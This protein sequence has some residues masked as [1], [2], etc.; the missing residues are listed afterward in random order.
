MK[1][2]TIVTFTGYVFLLAAGC[3]A[4]DNDD[5]GGETAIDSLSTSLSSSGAGPSTTSNDASGD[6][7]TGSADSSESG[8]PPAPTCNPPDSHEPNDAEDDAAELPEFS[9]QC[10]VDSS[11]NG[12]LAGDADIDWL[13]YRGGTNDFICVNDPTVDVVASG[14]IRFCQYVDCISGDPTTQ[15]C[16]SGTTADTSDD[17]GRPGCCTQGEDIAFSMYVGCSSDAQVF[18]RIDQGDADVC[19][20]YSLSYHF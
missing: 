5:G 7:Q 4:D 19:T 12:V 17:G 20:T 8:D 11:L 6:S 15:E 2:P 13:S 14:P 16:P 10:D 18:M 9:D 3:A 1:N